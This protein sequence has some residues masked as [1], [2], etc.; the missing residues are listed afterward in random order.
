AIT[1][2]NKKQ[3]TVSISSTEAEYRSAMEAAKEA[4]WL[5]RLFDEIKMKD[6]HSV[7]LFC[8]NQSTIALAHNPVQH[9]RMK[10]IEIHIHFIREKVLS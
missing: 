6:P 10:H 9:Q 1:W 2:C 7:P 5:K 3:P 4:L 8:D